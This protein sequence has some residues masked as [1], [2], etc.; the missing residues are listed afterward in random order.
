[1]S[2]PYFSPPIAYDLL[3]RAA[4]EPPR[5]VWDGYLAS[6]AITLLTSRWK[7]GK[8]TLLA[9][10]LAKLRAG[11]ELAG[12]AVAA[13]RAVVVSEEAPSLWADRGRRLGFGPHLSFLCRPFRGK[14]TAEA[15]EAL[16]DHL[17]AD[18]ERDGPALVVFD[19]L[20][21]VLPG[22]DENNAVSMLAALAPLQRLT[23]AGAAVLLLHHPRKADAAPRGSGALPGFADVLIELGGVGAGVSDDRRRRLR[24]VGRYAGT[25][26]EVV[27]ALAADGTDYA[28]VADADAGS[29]S[30]AGGW[31]VL[32]QV[33][34]DA[35]HRL[36]RKQ[37]LANW[38]DD[39]P[40]PGKSHLANWLERAVAAGLAARD[41][42][43]RKRDPYRYWL[44]G[45][46][47]ELRD[48]DLFLDELPPFDQGV[49]LRLAKA[50]VRN[51]LEG[52]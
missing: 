29:E 36:T 9:V 23:A 2:P 51:S 12:R 38:P 17:A 11:G 3:A 1:V 25:P 24:A 10:L 47:D 4:D 19:P 46:E 15:W 21:G 45:R 28:L 20:A 44:P 6:G 7:A 35:G 22:P 30:F 33:L 32:R 43:G 40:A 48:D 52:E 26:A 50:A 5:W 37:V 41:G 8:T 14:P 16:V 27:V 49:I 18:A 13:D 34:E 31:P 39:H 42:A